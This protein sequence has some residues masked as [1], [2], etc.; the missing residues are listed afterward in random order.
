MNDDQR[1]DEASAESFP[2][3]DPPA[4]T[5]GIEPPVALAVAAA[6]V[7]DEDEDEV[8]VEVEVDETG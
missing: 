2:A 1:V 6:R 4:W 7:E 8:E 3:S 5:M